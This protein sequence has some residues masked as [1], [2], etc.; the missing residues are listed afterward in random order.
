M[1][2][3]VRFKNKIIFFCYEKRSSLLQPWRSSLKF[4]SRRIDSCKGGE[5]DW[6]RYY[7][8]TL[9]KRKLITEWSCW[10]QSKL[11]LQFIRLYVY[12]ESQM[13]KKN[14][15]CPTFASHTYPDP[16]KMTHTHKHKHKH[17][18]KHWGRILAKHEN[19]N[20]LRF[21]DK[22]ENTL[23]EFSKMTIITPP[24]KQIPKLKWDRSHK[25]NLLNRRKDYFVRNLFQK[26][27]FNVRKWCNKI[28]FGSEDSTIKT[29]WIC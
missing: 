8:Y 19:A 11:F 2:S 17:K 9:C 7:F 1:R 22:K 26:L 15:R 18:H 3:L 20:T 23:S 29:I 24:R 10:P 13:L 21:F 16:N 5:E 4:K 14:R 25:T 28:A 27:F 12:L 6:L